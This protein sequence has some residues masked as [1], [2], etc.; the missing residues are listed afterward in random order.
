MQGTVPPGRTAKK[1]VTPISPI[2]LLDLAG[3]IAL[4]ISMLVD[5]AQSEANLH[6]YADMGET[7]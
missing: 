7:S 2:L 3:F 1:P 5:V 4:V 6:F